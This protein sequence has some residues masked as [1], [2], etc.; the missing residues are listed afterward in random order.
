MQIPVTPLAIFKDVEPAV[1][2]LS[3]ISAEEIAA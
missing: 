1:F 2:T 3:G